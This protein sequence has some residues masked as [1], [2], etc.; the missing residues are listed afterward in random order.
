MEEY[1]SEV[2]LSINTGDEE[3]DASIQELL[4]SFSLEEILERT[5]H[6]AG[7]TQPATLTLMVTDDA[8]IQDLN[9][10][11]RQ[12]DKPT[13]VLSFPMLDKPLVDAPAEQLW[14]LS[15][16]QTGEVGE[17]VE[18]KPAFVTPSELATNLGDIVISWP[19]VMRQAAEAEHAPVYELLYLFV[20][21]I[22][23]LVGYDDATEAG[24][25]AMVNF[26]RALLE[27]M[28]WKA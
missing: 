3:T 25:A 24:Y 16:E 7:I 18:D 5:L 4:S 17:A 23:H 21:G 19:I 15:Q 12:Q 11:Y 20:H 8:T 26:Q 13:D 1:T 9:K 2:E 22:L 27:T 10:R 14:A 6:A 28:E